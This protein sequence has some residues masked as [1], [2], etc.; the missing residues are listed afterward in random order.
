[1]LPKRR[2]TFHNHNAAGQF[3]SRGAIGRI[4][5]RVKD[6]TQK[7]EN[8]EAL[9]SEIQALRKEVKGL[10]R[11]HDVG[12]RLRQA[13]SLREGLAEVLS[14]TIDLLG[15]DMGDV[16]LLDDVGRFDIA[17]QRGFER[18]FARFFRDACSEDETAF[19][20][21]FRS[22]EPVTVE[23][24]ELDTAF[25][26]G[27]SVARAAGYRAFVSAPLIGR[28]GTLLGIVSTHFRSPHQPSNAD[29]QRLELY[30]RRAADFIERFRSDEAL[31]ETNAKLAAE[32]KSTA[33]FYEAGL[34]VLQAQTLSEALDILI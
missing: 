13:E 23:D 14:A 7:A 25:A 16:R 33:K 26:P 30:R 32:K 8:E 19:A 29:M 27:R 9:R 15:A 1:M 34:K 12:W 10:A 28:H 20:K 11:L 17:V 3:S 5:I 18:D 22:G 4:A 6:T 31:R 2:L 24:I 21:S